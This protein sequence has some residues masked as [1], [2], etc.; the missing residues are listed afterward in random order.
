MLLALNMGLLGFVALAKQKIDF[1]PAQV[2]L[3]QIKDENDVT[4]SCAC[5]V[6]S[7]LIGV[8]VRCC[9]PLNLS[10]ILPGA[11]YYKAPFK[12][13]NLPNVF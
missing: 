7:E 9:R 5:I 12:Y 2:S 13:S 1:Y 8:I 4:L 3:E 6:L 10:L 11:P